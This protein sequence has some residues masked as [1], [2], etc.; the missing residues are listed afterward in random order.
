LLFILFT[1]AVVCVEISKWTEG[2]LCDVEVKGRDSARSQTNQV[3]V[4][5]HY[6]HLLHVA[7]GASLSVAVQ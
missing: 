4:Q 6:H 2:A 5:R 7:V 1:C 3:Y